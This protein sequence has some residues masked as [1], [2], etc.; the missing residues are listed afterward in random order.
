MYMCCCTC[1]SHSSPVWPT[2]VG[3]VH[4]LL[5]VYVTFISSMADKCRTCTCVAARVCHIHLQYGRQV[6][7]MYMCCCTCMSQSSP[8]WPTSV[9]HVHVLLHVYVTS[10][11][12]LHY[13]VCVIGK[14][15][16]R[17]TTVPLLAHLSRRLR[18]ELLVYQ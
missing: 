2:S 15:K 1:M 13:L 6:S 16:K 4:V 18:G 14:I 11:V 8:A 10:D 17:N 3:H 12:D 9:V 7:D 5:H